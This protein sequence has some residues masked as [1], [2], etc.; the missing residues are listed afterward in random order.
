MTFDKHYVDWNYK[1]IKKIISHFGHEA[2]F[3]KTVLDLGC[4]HADISG[5]LARLGARVIAVDARQEHLTIAK[6]KYPHITT[7]CV[8]LD[9]NWPFGNQRF[10][11]VLAMGVVCHLSSYKH[12]LHKAA[13]IS[14]NLILES[15][16]CDSEDPQRVVQIDEHRS[17]Y[18]WA[19]NGVGNK[20]SATHLE[21]ILQESGMSF[22]RFDSADINSG[23][24]VY[25]WSVSHSQSR[26]IGGRRLWIAK[27]SHLPATINASQVQP[28]I[29]DAPISINPGPLTIKPEFVYNEKRTNI[30]SKS[31]FKVAVCISGYMR[32][33]EQTF[34]RL[35][36]NLL[37][38][39]NPDIFIHTWNYMGSPLRGFDNPMIRVSTKSMLQRINRLYKP[40][41]LI[42]EPAINFKP[43]PLMLQRNFDNRDI[44]GVLSMFYKVKVCNDLKKE[45]EQNNDF[46][47][48]CVIRM[49]SDLMFMSPFYLNKDMDKNTLYVPTGYDYEGMN[50]QIAYGSS[51]IM[52]KYCD[53]Y[54]NIDQLLRDGEKFNPEKLVKQH[55]LKSGLPLVRSNMHYYIKRAV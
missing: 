14:D 52:D 34:D 39:T 45:H 42:V 54:D 8:D 28:I 24:F 40:T 21:Q 13:L 17:I 22:Q 30:K 32:T 12:L 48:D 18:D 46:K 23:P 47:Y 6:R 36:N 44:N 29:A 27:K 16:V 10:D 50:D 7:M 15:E 4:G 55:V 41:Q 20:P 3:D 33:F 11:F 38:Q 37:K 9:K 1:R 25:D 5:A 53:L 35:F 19:F 2:F 31:D 51:E 26:K 49:R 43:T